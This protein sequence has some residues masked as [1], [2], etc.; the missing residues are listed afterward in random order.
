MARDAARSAERL[1]RIQQRIDA[2]RR[3]RRIESLMP[4]LIILGFFG[5]WQLFVVATGTKDFILPKP[6]A[7]AASMVQWWEPLLSNAAQTFFNTGV[8]FALAVMFGLATGVL[9]G[10]STFVYRGVYPLLIGFNSVPKVAI[11]PILVI[12][13]GTNALPAIITAFAI[14]F[15][16]IVVNVATGIATIEPEQRD[17]LRALGARPID[18]VRK[19]GLPRAMP[20]FFAS[21]KIAITVA[22]V[23]SITAETVSSDAGI[24][25]LMIVASSRFEVPLVFAG[26]MVTAFMGVAMYSV[27]AFIEN[28]T[29][30]W[31]TRGTRDL[32][33]AGY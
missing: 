21:L 10:S 15:F 8:G 18:I 22:F 16:P 20:Y 11:V 4:W 26:L 25:H 30:T 6:T 28:R 23:G 24:G 14:S 7:I 5:L 13:F 27:A 3:R 29:T 9:V 19:V 33:D 12:W 1:R 2:L 31:A 17:V 32:A